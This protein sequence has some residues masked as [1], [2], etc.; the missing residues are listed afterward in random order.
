MKSI[1]PIN[2]KAIEKKQKQF[3]QKAIDQIRKQTGTQAKI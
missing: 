3:I 1:M 2:K